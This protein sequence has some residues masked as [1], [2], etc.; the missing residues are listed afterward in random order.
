MPAFA[1]LGVIDIHALTMSIKSGIHAEIRVALDTLTLLASEP[2]VQISLD[3]CDDLVESLVECA[4]DQLELLAEHA[5]EVSDDMLLSSYEEI[6][7]GCQAEWTSLADVPEFGSLDY[8]LD[9]S[10]DRLICITTILRN[11]SFTESNFGVLSNPTVVNLIATIIRYLG[12]RNMLLRTYQNTLDFMKDAV[13]YLSNLAH[14]IQLSGKEEAIC[15]LHFLLSFAPFPL[16]TV[17]PEGILFTPY[18]AAIHK[19]TPSAVDGL[20]KLL[21][22]DD[23]NR[24][25]FRSIFSED[26]SS[27]PQPELLTR[28]FGLAICPVPDQPRKPLAIAD[29]RKVFLLQGLLAADLLAGF[30]D[31]PLAKAW[32]ESIDGFA[33]HLL[34]LSCL[35]STERVPP[36]FNPHMRQNQAAR[37]Q[38]EAEAY[39]YSSSSIE[40]WRSCAGWLR[41][42][43]KSTTLQTY[44]FHLGSSR[45]KKVYW[46]HY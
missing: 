28:A 21:A 18:N 15:L 10:V 29:A 12:T 5:A 3:H 26:A 24:S 37:S 34:R 36:P 32:L 31:G 22:R 4:E 9:R 35:M 44:D 30:A 6:T 17:S 23:P 46:G 40:D 1:E 20:A 16:P 25:F 41:N 11:F 2:G 19:Y 14:F 42:R 43:S 8:D 45:R 13:I 33:I 38:A 27:P 7:R 39:A